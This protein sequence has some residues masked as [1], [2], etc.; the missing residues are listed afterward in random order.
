MRTIDPKHVFEMICIEQMLYDYCHELD[1]GAAR[2]TDYFTEDCVFVV[3]DST[4]RGHAGL[5][6]HYAADA[7][8]VRTYYEGGVRTVRHGLL[9]L[10]THVREGGAATVELIFL[11]FS[12]GGAAPFLKASAPTVVADTRLELTREADGHWRMREFYARPLYFGDD[13]YLNTVLKEM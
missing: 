9:N 11:N 3:G 12:A 5:R 6:E 2:V 13:P 1:A 8:A 7:Q 10:R 4:W